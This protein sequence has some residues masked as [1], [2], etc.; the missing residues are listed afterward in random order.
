MITAE[1]AKK[2]TEKQ[3]KSNIKLKTL[4]NYT[5]TLIINETKKGGNYINVNEYYV[6]DLNDE[7]IKKYTETLKSLGYDVEEIFEIK[8]NPYYDGIT[9]GPTT[10][11][12]LYYKITW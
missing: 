3:K 6:N 12:L 11:K 5:D 7:E 1:E 2:I 9:C 8:T 4:L 10:K